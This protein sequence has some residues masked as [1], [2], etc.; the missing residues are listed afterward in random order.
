MRSYPAAR[1]K[2]GT[3]TTG[4]SLL[5]AFYRERFRVH[6]RRVAA[7]IVITA[8]FAGHFSINARSNILVSIF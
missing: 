3:L 4:E 2:R 1:Q 6:S 7:G 8:A 5:D